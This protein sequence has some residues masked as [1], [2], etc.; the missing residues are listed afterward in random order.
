MDIGEGSRSV[1]IEI[2][3]TKVREGSGSSV[4]T[5]MDEFLN[6]AQSIKNG[7]SNKNLDHLLKMDADKLRKLAAS[8]QP[9]SLSKKRSMTKKIREIMTQFDNTKTLEQA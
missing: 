8:V 1:P 5:G 4:E 7:I 9:L 3:V 2:L 6:I